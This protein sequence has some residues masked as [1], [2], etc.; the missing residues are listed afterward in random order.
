VLRLDVWNPIRAGRN[1]ILVG[2]AFFVI[3]STLPRSTRGVPGLAESSLAKLAALVET[4][5]G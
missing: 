4:Q 5:R 2:V 3:V 1:W